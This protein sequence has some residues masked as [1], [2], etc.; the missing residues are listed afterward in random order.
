MN[1][2]AENGCTAYLSAEGFTLTINGNANVDIASGNNSWVG[3]GE[4]SSSGGIVDF[5]GN[6]TI[7]TN[8]ATSGSGKRSFF[9]GRSSSKLIFRADL[10]LGRTCVISSSRRPGTVEFDGVGLQQV[11]WNNDLYFANFYDVVV[12]NVNNPIVRHVTG[13]YTPDNILNSLTINGSSTLDLA[14][15]QW[16]RD[17]AGGSFTMNGTSSM[18]LG[19]DHSIP[20]PANGRGIVI[21]GSNFPGGFN[22]VTIASGTTIEYD[23]DNAMTQTVYDLPTY[24]NLTLTNS[25]G[26]G[27]ASK[28]TTAAVTISGTSNVKN[29][30]TFTPGAGITSNG[31]FNVNSGA[32]L[33][34]A[35]NVI[36]GSGSFVLKSGGTINIGST[37]GISA[38]GATGN[39]TTT[40]RNYST[41]ANYIYNSSGASVTGNGLP[42]LVNDLTINNASGVTLFAGSTNYT[43]GGT[44]RLTAG[45]FLINGNTLTINSLIR[46]SGSLR[47]SASSSLTVNG[48][49]T[50]LFFTAGGR[51]IK[52]FTMGTNA[53]ASLLTDMEIPGGVN[54]GTVTIGSG[55]TLTTNSRLILRSTAT[56]TARVAEIPVDGSGNAL[57]FISGNVQV[58]RFLSARRAWRFLSVVTSGSQTI[59]AAWQEGQAANVTNPAGYGIQITGP[60][61]PNGFD[62][63]TITP[64]MKTYVPLTDTWAS[65]SGTNI[66]FTAGTAYMTFVRGDRTVNAFG[67]AATSTILRNRG[68][69]ITGNQSA[70][71]VGA[72]KFAAINNPFA[73]DINFKNVLK[74][75]VDDKF[76]VWD[77][78]LGTLGAY[79][80][81]IKNGS[82]D[83][84]IV[85]GGG[86]Y[87]SAGTVYNDI[88]NGQA[89]MVFATGTSG[90]LTLQENDKSV[91]VSMVSRE[92]INAATNPVKQLRTRLFGTNA[93]GTNLVDGVLNQ[94][95]NEYSNEVDSKDALKGFSFGENLSLK[96]ANKLLVVDRRKEVVST[97]TIYFNLSSTK[98]QQYKF[99]FIPSNLG[100]DGLTAFFQDS[101]LQTSTPLSL[102]DSSEYSFTIV[103]IPGSYA[104]NRF[105]IVF[106]RPAPA[107]ITQ[108]SAARNNGVPVAVNWQVQHEN[109]VQQYELEHSTNGAN[110]SRIAFVDPNGTTNAST[111]AYQYVDQAATTGANFYRVKVISTCGGPFYSDTVDVRPLKSAAI[112]RDQNSTS[113]AAT[114][115]VDEPQISV[116]PNP[117]SNK[118]M[119]VRFVNM[120][121]GDYK[122][123]LTNLS[124]QSVY[125]TRVSVNNKAATKMVALS[126]TLA[127]GNYQLKITSADGQQVTQQVVIQ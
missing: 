48:T 103:N 81:F 119:N 106:N 63:Y 124:G 34:C 74:S 102:N 39:I 123:E 13:T 111:S 94:F 120:N 67:Q 100:T 71:T 97:D 15:S 89:F 35:N 93:E 58:E 57:G 104:Q 21:P 121:A 52:N 110:F 122:I 66:P 40:T 22:T 53:T 14:G 127:A 44:L 95:D 73:S 33:V 112:G 17:D 3:I 87:G 79:Q 23:G 45:S 90:T 99:Q 46:T 118:Q 24:G 4:N 55:A 30:V 77:P 92:N 56:G 101:Y 125:S 43:V 69:I 31:T 7:G 10:L 29:G 11:L 42:T 88:P 32:T 84:E 80:T 75:N 70:V 1:F 28:I 6:V 65:I 96:T 60:Y 51:I 114:A 85:L 36:S 12:G 20:S 78:Y 25:T 2:T 83:Y 9:L 86:S 68:P 113:L 62:L 27:T 18:I 47:G 108:V 126:K 64:S 61:Y 37:Q 109:N 59:N 16:I 49:G 115:P 117:V 76:Y 54:A 41:G 107:A 98:A 19:N 105:R 50:P 26:S 5:K 82:G 8:A 116:F 38:S 72:N 91:G